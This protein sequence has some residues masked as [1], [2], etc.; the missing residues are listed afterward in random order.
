MRF[1][2]SKRKFHL[3]EEMQFHA[4]S[5]FGANPKFHHIHAISEDKN[6]LRNLPSTVSKNLKFEITNFKVSRSFALFADKKILAQ[7]VRG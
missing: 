2:G 5:F 6:T 7:K 1:G 3:L 4:D